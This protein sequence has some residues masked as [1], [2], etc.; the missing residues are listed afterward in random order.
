M[1]K[2]SRIISQNFYLFKKYI[3]GFLFDV[4]IRHYETNGLKFKIPFK[5]TTRA[6]R[7]RFFLGKYESKEEY[8]FIQKYLS[9]NDIVLELGACI[10]VLSCFVNRWLSATKNHVVV[11]ANP[12]LI[13]YLEHNR[14]WNSCNFNIENCMISKNKRNNFYLHNMIIGGSDKRKTNKKIEVAGKTFQEIEKK[15]N[16]SFSALIIDIEGGELQLLKENQD[17][18]KQINILFIEVHPF[19]NILTKEEVLLCEEILKSS[20]LKKVDQTPN[21]V[22]Q[23]WQ[24]N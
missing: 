14:N 7:G 18:L 19:A 10:G 23:V 2:I 22:Y 6:F 3:S 5:L 1:K 11:E 21:N 8:E 20:S 16:L 15:Y 9:K 13:E 24:R 17:Y 12:L 4:F